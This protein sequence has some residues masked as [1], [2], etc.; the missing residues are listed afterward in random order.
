MNF[1]PVLDHY[2]LA[3]DPEDAAAPPQV[4][5][6]LMTGFDADEGEIF[7]QQSLSP[8]AFEERVRERYGQFAA[9]FLKVYPHASAE[10]ATR[11]ATQMGRDR[12]MASL[13]LWLDGRAR[14]SG[15]V[16]YAYLFEHPLPGPESS[17]YG[18]FHTSEVPYVFGVLDQ[19]QRPFQD[20]DR[21]VSAQLSAYWLNFMRSGDP[22]G[23]HLKVWAPFAADRPVVMGLGD[24]VG[25]RDAVSSPA[26]LAVFRAYVAQGGR[27]S[28][29]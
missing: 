15:Q 11:S 29:F 7:A 1:A 9:E 19:A 25:P 2:V 26:R 5:V 16:L 14:Q 21:Q 22:N 13:V 28:L 10:E 8:S 17:R 12:Y 3:A 23:R 20:Q 4:H 24:Q 27:L 6:P 18:T